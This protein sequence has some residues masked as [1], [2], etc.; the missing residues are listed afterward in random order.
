MS[1]HEG[2]TLAHRLVVTRLGDHPTMRLE[3]GQVPRPGPGQVLVETHAAGLARVDLLQRAGRHPGGPRPPFVPGRDVVGSVIA[4]GQGVSERWSGLRVAAHLTGGGHATHVTVPAARLV[5]L[6]DDV[7][8]TRA[9]CLPLNYLA[10]CQLLRSARLA[11]GDAVY[12]DGASGGIG[13][14]LLDLAG[15]LG[16]V[17]TGACS[18]A[19][20]GVV[21]RFGAA[22]VDRHAADLPALVRDKIGEVAPAGVRAAFSGG[23]TTSLRVS[24]AVLAPG[25]LLAAYGGDVGP[26]RRP[27]PPQARLLPRVATLAG[28]AASG[29][30]RVT[31]YS[32][33]R[34]VDR[35]PGTARDDLAHLIGLLAG[36]QIDPLVAAELPLGQADEAYRLLESG[37]VAGKIVLVP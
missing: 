16:V 25:G 21:E 20:N 31:A 36:G 22:P 29:R 27:P 2:A 19:K 6:P 5:T 7:S 34:S 23:G 30:I 28:W 37:T 8:A 32:A 4:V 18:P 11:P 9:A 26:V 17:A 33:Q 3:P 10:A 13:T 14:A 15:G 24:R 1:R 35:H 12:V